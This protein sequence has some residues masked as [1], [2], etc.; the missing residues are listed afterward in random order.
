MLVLTFVILNVELKQ[1][2]GKGKRTANFVETNAIA[3]YEGI[4]TGF[5]RLYLSL[6]ITITFTF[7]YA[8]WCLYY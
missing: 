1:R 8:K 6:T 3:D 4:T 5:S 7:N 2:D